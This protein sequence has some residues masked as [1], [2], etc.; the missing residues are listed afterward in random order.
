MEMG[1]YTEDLAKD[2]IRGATGEVVKSVPLLVA[3][4]TVDICSLIG[5]KRI[6]QELSNE[7]FCVNIS[8]SIGFVKSRCAYFLPAM[9]S[10][11]QE[12]LVAVF[13]SKLDTG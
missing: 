11:S 1:D 9:H 10:A 13:R 7:T 2:K 6:S 4:A 3:A 12:K 5:T 8:R